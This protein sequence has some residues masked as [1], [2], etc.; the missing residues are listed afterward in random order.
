[1]RVSTGDQ[2]SFRMSKHIAPYKVSIGQVNVVNAFVAP[3]RCRGN[4]GVVDFAAGE[5]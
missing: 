2:A 3:Y 4:I 1:M 5:F